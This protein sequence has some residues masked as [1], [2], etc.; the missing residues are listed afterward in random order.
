MYLKWFFYITFTKKKPL[1][2]C[3]STGLE[4]PVSISILE[5]TK[6]TS[7]IIENGGNWIHTGSV[8]EEGYLLLQQVKASS[9]L[10][11]QVKSSS[12]REATTHISDNHSNRVIPSDSFSTS[13]ENAPSI[14][15]FDTPDSMGIEKHP[16]HDFLSDVLKNSSLVY[17]ILKNLQKSKTVY[18]MDTGGQ[19]E[20]HELLPPILHGPALHLIFFNASLKLNEPVKVK[21]CHTKTE[22]ESVQ[23]TASSSSIEV[24]HQLLSTLYSLHLQE[25]SR[26][27]KAVVLGS[28]IDLLGED[29]SQRR[30]K[31]EEISHLLKQ[32]I[33]NTDYYLLSSSTGEITTVKSS[34]FGFTY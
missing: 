3:P 11:Q 9:L 21:F 30:Y 6:F 28:H 8:L 4:C 10:L 5:R 31:I 13:I 20:F 24:I 33:E 14:G 22:I 17:E 15:H 12:S 19:P 7:A 23:Y 2:E 25:K 32:Y 26:Q 29:E 34:C 27:S 16:V 1:F 18:F